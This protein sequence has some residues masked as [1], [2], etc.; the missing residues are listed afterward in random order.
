VIIA[1][2]VVLVVGVGLFLLQQGPKP[3][4]LPQAAQTDINQAL[5]SIPPGDAAG[6]DL[7]GVP[8]PGGSTR[9]YYVDRGQVRTA[10]YVQHDPVP[11]VR[12]QL[13]VALA[14]ASWRPVGND[15][16]AAPSGTVGADR[17]WQGVFSTG[18]NVLQVEI[19]RKTDVT[20]TTFILQTS[21]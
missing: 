21:P 14:S 11:T 1:A 17:I 18:N 2:G 13:R 4:T 16:S 12:D 20:A 15:P 6:K 19:A 10:I 5:G 9:S 7:P 3:N 8:R